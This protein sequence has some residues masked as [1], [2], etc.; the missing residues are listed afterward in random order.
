[1]NKTIPS[2]KVAKEILDEML[3]VNAPYWPELH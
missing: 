1:M 3:E 2:A